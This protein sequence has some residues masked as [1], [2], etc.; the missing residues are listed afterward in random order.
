MFT[1]VSLQQVSEEKVKVTKKVVLDISIDG[2]ASGS[3]E[4]GLFGNTVPRTVD[5]FVQLA[6]GKNGYGYKGSKFHR[7]IKDFMIQGE[8]QPF[9][10]TDMMPCCK[11]LNGM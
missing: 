10:T 11:S 8:I 3:I 4:I 5:N 2:K 1:H 6:T 7:I 9:L